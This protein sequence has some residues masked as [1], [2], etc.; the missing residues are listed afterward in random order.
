MLTIKPM[1]AVVYSSQPPHP[2]SVEE[3]ESPKLAPNCIRV[4]VKATALN[5]ADLMQKQGLYPPP[6]GASEILGLEAAGEVIEVGENCQK[7][8]LGDPVMA[9]LAGGGYAEEVVVHEACAMPKPEYLSFSEATA[10]PEA[11]LTAYQAL[12]FL[13]HLTEGEKILIHGGASGV[14]T[15]AIQLAKAKG[16][17]VFTTA[18][19]PSKCEYL[20]EELRADHAFN[21]KTDDF[22]QQIKE[23]TQNKGVQIIIDIAGG[24]HYEQNMKSIGIDGQ[25]IVL[26]FMGGRYAQQFDFAKLLMK[27]VHLM[28]STLRARS[29]D[30]KGQLVR[31]FADAFLPLFPSG[32]LKP[33]I[34]KTYP[35]EQANEAHAR[36][37]ANQNI[38]KIILE[39]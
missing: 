18:G 33:I 28:G 23:I 4:K 3:V 39:L 8:K 24:S 22:A 11:F 2:L 36:M 9:L 27:R 16:A 31:E 12:F 17:E 10:I 32:K 14:G 37:E 15:A 34:D 25:W 1:K 5:R 7:F 20:L 30:Y 13:G 26:A 19:T 38:G 29:N 35:W 6:A 21:Y